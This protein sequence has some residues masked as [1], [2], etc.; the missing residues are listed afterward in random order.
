LVQMLGGDGPVGASL[1]DYDGNLIVYQALVY[2]KG[3][4]FLAQ[5]RELLGDEDFFAL[6]GQHYQAHKYGLLAAGDFRRS[7]EAATGNADALALYD[8]VVVRGEALEG[9]EGLERLE[10]LSDLLGDELTLEDVESWTE[11]FEELSQSTER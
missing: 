7:I 8:A 1:L 5:L 10:G 4:L 3:A 2:G 6:L 11:L 9:L